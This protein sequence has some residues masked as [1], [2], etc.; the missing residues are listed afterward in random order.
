MRFTVVPGF[1]MDGAESDYHYRDPSNIIKVADTYYLW[2]NRYS[3]SA[4]GC[5]YDG[6]I[7]F[8]VSKDLVHWRLQGEALGAG[9]PGAWDDHCA[10]TPYVVEDDGKF[11]M[12]YTAI[13]GEFDKRTTWTGLGLAVSAAPSGPWQRLPDSNILRRGHQGEWDDFRVDGTTV[14]KGPDKRW[15]LF[16]K[17]TRNPP[18]G[19]RKLGLSFADRL[20]GPWYKYSRNPVLTHTE[21][22]EGMVFF[23]R[24]GSLHLLVD[25]F[26]CYDMMYFTSKNW[27]DWKKGTPFIPLNLRRDTG[28][29]YMLAAPGDFVAADG[30]M[31]MV[32]HGIWEER[33]PNIRL[34]LLQ[35]GIP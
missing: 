33:S 22:F 14:M 3:V 32:V 20:I 27:I 10:I 23:Q 6:T 1:E 24:E 34:R 18:E 11:Y 13:S 28:S 31:F 19:S 17:G 35:V 5:G 12:F 25:R 30:S 8:A 21:D 7:W 9:E 16:Y 15:W 4:P 2:F 29:S 26:G